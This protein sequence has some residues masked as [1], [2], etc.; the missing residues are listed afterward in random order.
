MTE[1]VDQLHQYPLAR[2]CPMHPPREYDAWRSDDNG[3]SRVVLWNTKPAWVITSFEAAQR[4][5]REAPLGADRTNPG[6]PIE[7]P[8][9]AGGPTGKSFRSMDGEPHAFYRRLLAREFSARAIESIRPRIQ[10]ILGQLIANIK[11]R[12]N[13]ADL[14]TD[15]A[16]PLTMQVICTH[17]GVPLKDRLAF[18]GWIT[19]LLGRT[20]DPTA[21]REAGASISNYLL[22]LIDHKIA[23]PADDLISR[24]TSGPLE[25]GEISRED[26]LFTIMILLVG[27]YES[28]ASSMST[29]IFALLE[30]PEQATRVRAGLTPEEAV[31]MVEEVLRFTSVTDAGADRYV[32]EDFEMFGTQFHAGDGVIFHLPSA[33]RDPA[34]YENPNEFDIGRAGPRHLAFGHGPHQCVGQN[35]ARAEIL[36]AI[37][38]IFRE[39]PNLRLTIPAEDVAFRENALVLGVSTL[40]VTWDAP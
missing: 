25:R 15:L 31:G 30:T 37:P 23:E 32:V 18:D 5:L 1:S 27:G 17:L 29:G 9:H 2:G 10:Q 6:Y 36:E 20:G 26:A 11:S 4:M 40:P 21:A 35:L 12:G 34:A 16:L 8:I 7:A 22:N 33:N 24:V 13:T 14:V 19:D 39:L 38:T 28:T 3:I